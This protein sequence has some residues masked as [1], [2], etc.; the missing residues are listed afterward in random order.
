[1]DAPEPDT[2]ATG[3]L[4]TALALFAILV[5]ALL[6][7]VFSLPWESPS[8]DETRF[9][10]QIESSTVSGLW[11][12]FESTDPKVRLTPVPYLAWNLWARLLGN[13]VPVL[14]MFPV[15]CS[16]GM[17]CLLFLLARP[18]YGA[19]AA[20]VSASMAAVSL[21][22]IFQAQAISP[23]AMIGL[24]ALASLY[25]FSRAVHGAG[26][27]AWAALILVDTI[28]PWTH[29]A[30][31]LAWIPQAVFLA[32]FRRHWRTRVLAWGVGHAGLLALFAGWVD[33]SGHLPRPEAIGV[34]ASPKD[35]V[36]LLLVF[37]GGRF[38]SADPAGYMREGASFDRILAAGLF[39]MLVADTVRSFRSMNDPEPTPEARRAASEAWFFWALW[40]M[41]PPCALA[42]A[43]LGWGQA[44]DVHLVLFASLALYLPAGRVLTS[45]SPPA[46]RAA[47][48]AAFLAMFAA[49]LTVIPGGLRPDYRAAADFLIRNGQPKDSILVFG[50]HNAEALEFD[51][52]MSRERIESFADRE[53]LI[54]RASYRLVH[55]SGVW[56]VTCDPQD[57]EPLETGLK[58]REIA[59]RRFEFGGHPP[60]RVYWLRWDEP[61]GDA[62]IALLMSQDGAPSRL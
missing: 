33:F 31:A 41:L 3:L 57:P 56:L 22:H 50:A 37:S 5:F 35:I 28:I 12:D 2:A 13:S 9:I 47:L 58:A 46:A 20:L 42:L 55:A 53:A 39:F 18:L 4:H 23:D 51:S 17:V 24:L 29:P 6:L 14:R 60:V 7:R 43:N 32:V 16:I 10:A 38:S 61:A 52:P 49:Q 19:H 11:G 48:A 1:M 36:D 15:V 40:A 54:G 45:G 27:W 34:A 44:F 62:M 30:A 25:A 26:Y 8:R 59:F 21:P